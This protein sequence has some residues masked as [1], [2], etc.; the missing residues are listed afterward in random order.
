MTKFETFLD[1]KGD[2]PQA[3]F[4]H[5]LTLIEKN[6]L[7]MFGGA[8]GDTAKYTMT[9]QAFTFN[10]EKNEWSQIQSNIIKQQELFLHL[11]P[12]TQLHV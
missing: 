2:I 8:I 11:E 6:I 10:T 9:D 7:I 1:A 3:R 4:G 5:T 12:H